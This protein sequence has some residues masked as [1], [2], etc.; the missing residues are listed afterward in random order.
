MYVL[1]IL[2]EQ[3]E[4]KIKRC[5]NVHWLLLTIYSLFFSKIKL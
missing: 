5:F 2:R 3:I 4:S 1:I